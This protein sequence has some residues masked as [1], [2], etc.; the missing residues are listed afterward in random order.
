MLISPPFAKVLTSSKK[1]T[2]R[3]WDTSS[4]GEIS[5]LG[6]FTNRVTAAMFNADGSKVVT[7]TGNYDI[8]IWDTLSGTELVNIPPPI[9]YVEDFVSHGDIFE[10]VSSHGEKLYWWEDGS[11]VLDSDY[12][13]K[14]FTCQT[15]LGK[16]GDVGLSLRI[17][18]RSKFRAPFIHLDAVLFG[19]HSRINPTDPLSFVA[20]CADGSVRFFHLEGVELPTFE[21]TA[22]KA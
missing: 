14:C 15:L 17:R 10:V 11:K 5:V 13:M 3:V 7:C 1:D 6:S 12:L 18:G 21:Q 9:G 2:D 19:A 16:S 22:P 20:G 8:Q 4:G